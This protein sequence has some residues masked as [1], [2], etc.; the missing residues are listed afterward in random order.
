MNS[1]ENEMAPYQKEKFSSLLADLI[2]E[3]VGSS[4]QVSAEEIA[5]AF[6]T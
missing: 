6:W 4:C 2:Q 1:A 3:T 5:E